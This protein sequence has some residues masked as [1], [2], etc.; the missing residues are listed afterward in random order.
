MHTKITGYHMC[1]LM[2]S[3]LFS[4]A[5]RMMTGPRVPTQQCFTEKINQFLNIQV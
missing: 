3:N 4:A 5:V 1:K 2:C